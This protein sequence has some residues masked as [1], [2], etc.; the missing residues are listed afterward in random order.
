MAAHTSNF[1]Q[2]SVKIILD[3]INE[4]NSATISVPYTEQ[5]L[6]FGVPAISGGSVTGETLLDLTGIGRAKGTKQIAYNRV[7]LATLNTLEGA[8][9]VI[10]ATP[11]E[12][13]GDIAARLNTRF[14]V[15]LEETDVNF[16]TVIPAPTEEG[17]DFTIPALAT[18]LVWFG[19]V[20]VKLSTVRVDINDEIE[21]TEQDG[22]YA[23]T[24]V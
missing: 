22:L 6:S 1:Q 9:I 12:T 23:P 17:T 15:Q 20:A 10:E 2:S 14:N 18:S 3:L 21:L 8:D 7:T 4:Q 11:G 19:S 24:G 13:V 5:S 16:A